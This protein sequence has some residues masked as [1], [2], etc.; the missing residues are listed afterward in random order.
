MV[1][2]QIEKKYI[3]VVYKGKETV[4]QILRT[5]T[6]ADIRRAIECAFN[7]EES[8]RY[9]LKNINTDVILTSNDAIAF[10]FE[11]DPTIKYQIVRSGEQFG[12]SSRRRWWEG[13]WNALKLG[14]GRKS[15]C[16]T[17]ENFK[18]KKVFNLTVAYFSLFYRFTNC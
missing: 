13:W 4:F 9:Y 10:W 1:E 6:S 14:E 17:L 7:F 16:H 3:T 11:T 5:S 8:A 2:S 15:Q 12:A 18:N